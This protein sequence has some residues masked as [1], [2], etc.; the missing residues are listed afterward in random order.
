MP[1]PTYT[2][3]ATVTLGADAA[4]VTFSSIP[5]TYR[6]LI[7]ILNGQSTAGEISFRL[8]ADSGSNYSQVFMR[9]SSTTQSGASTFN[10]AFPFINSVG[11]ATRLVGQIQF[12]DYSATDKH[13]TNL[14]R[15]GYVQNSDSAFSTEATAIRWANTAAI[16]TIAFTSTGSFASGSTFNLYGIA[17]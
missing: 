6:D 9:G 12:M 15:T 17:S 3:L 16:T 4:S 7:L 5:A 14:S 11:N 1:T 13:K 2:P 10:K 8:N